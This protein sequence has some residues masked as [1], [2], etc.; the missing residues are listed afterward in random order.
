MKTVN[1][2]VLTVVVG[3]CTLRCQLSPQ[4]TDSRDPHLMD[5]SHFF[6]HYRP[7]ANANR[8]VYLDNRQIEI[9]RLNDI[10]EWLPPGRHD[11]DIVDSLTG[12]KIKHIDLSLQECTEQHLTIN[13]SNGSL[14]ENAE[15]KPVKDAKRCPSLRQP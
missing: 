10:G 6:L 3:L 9:A 1:L 2:I 5:R 14:K 15:L 13:E 4:L 11:L 7:Q 8:S 12:T